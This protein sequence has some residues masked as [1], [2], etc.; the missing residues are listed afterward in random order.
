MVSRVLIDTNILLDY[1]LTREPYF[2]NANK[3]ILSCTDGNVKGC[4]AAHSITNMFYIMRKDVEPHKRR[5]ILINLS[6]IFD[7]VGIEKSKLIACLKNEDIPD[8]ED[9]LQTECARE[10]GAEYI[11]TR[12]I[13]DFKES[14][15]KAITPEEYLELINL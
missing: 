7:I 4:I 5:E 8:F 10:Y 1:L 9:C 12:N 15:V 14:A 13:N 2:D 6:M 3:V 11:V